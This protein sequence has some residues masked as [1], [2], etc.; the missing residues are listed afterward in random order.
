MNVRRAIGLVVIFGG[1]LLPILAQAGEIDEIILNRE[2]T[3]ANFFGVNARSMAL[4]RTGIAAANDGSALIYNPAALARIRRLEVIGGLSNFKTDNTTDFAPNRYSELTS[5]VSR[6]TR[7]LTKTRLSALSVSVP[8]PT[9]RGSLVWALGVHRVKNFDR[10]FEFELRDAAAPD[11]Y[12]VERQT[13]TETGGITAWSGGAAIELSPRLAVG[14]ALHVYTGTD[15]YVADYR[16]K[17]FAITDSIVTDEVTSIEA[18][19]LG[20]SGTIGLTYQLSPLVSLGAVIET[21]S[22]WDI[23]EET[24]VDGVTTWD[25]LS[26]DYLWE[27]TYSETDFAEYQL[28]HPFSFGMGI[29]FIQN[30]LILTGDIKYTDWSQFEYT[31]WPSTAEAEVFYRNLNSLAQE[32]FTEVLAVGVGAEYVF[33]E[34]GVSLRAGG[35]LDPLPFPDEYIERDRRYFTFGAGFLVDRVMTIDVGVGLGGYSINYLDKQPPG[36]DIMPRPYTEEYDERRVY[37][38]LAYRM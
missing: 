37:L 36:S 26:S 24:I 1:L 12:V 25:T 5:Q 4:G 28:R 38:T 34:H 23:E 14:G 16:F 18:D 11:D 27:E 8:V 2:P 7:D 29:E 30:Q 15:E 20:I 35:Y 6:G 10:G 21:P 13:E 3:L 31:D 33:P 17:D 22:F 32:H 19:H 9:Y